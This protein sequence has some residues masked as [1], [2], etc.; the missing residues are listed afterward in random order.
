MKRILCVGVIK[1]GKTIIKT[2]NEELI[3]YVQGK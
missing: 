3:K 2:D 1:S